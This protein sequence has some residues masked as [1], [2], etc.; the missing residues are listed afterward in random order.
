ME[1]YNEALEI[2]ATV[3]SGVSDIYVVFLNN[4]LETKD[5]T[6]DGVHTSVSLVI[7]KLVRNTWIF[8]VYLGP[9]VSET[10]IK[11]RIINRIIGKSFDYYDNN[12]FFLLSIQ[13]KFFHLRLIINLADALLKYRTLPY[14]LIFF[15]VYL[16]EEKIILKFVSK[17]LKSIIPTKLLFV[18]L[19]NN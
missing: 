5:I 7:P 9:T 16:W 10:E 13:N 17:H 14:F 1:K 3:L 6:N 15:S 18:I 4:L 8:Y 2:V 12:N 11:P 19:T